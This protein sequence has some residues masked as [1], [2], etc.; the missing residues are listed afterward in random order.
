VNR[1]ASSA[2]RR[3]AISIR[4]INSRL[5]VLIYCLSEMDEVRAISLRRAQP[6]EERRY[7]KT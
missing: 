7:A 6:K 2:L 4:Y 5:Y 1:M 3:Q